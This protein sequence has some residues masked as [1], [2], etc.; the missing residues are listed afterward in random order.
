LKE[1]ILTEP[2]TVKIDRQYQITL[3]ESVWKTL[4]L[5]PGDQLR[6]QIEDNRIVLGRPQPSGED[7]V[8]RLIGLHDEI[9]QSVD[10][11]AYLDKERAGWK[12]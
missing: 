2:I 11:A 3:P 6:I 8:E 10:A 9:W 4:E 7:V 12:K 5:Q 1:I